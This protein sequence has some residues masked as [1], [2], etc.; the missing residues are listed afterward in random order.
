[1]PKLCKHGAKICGV[2]A[3]F[4]ACVNGLKSDFS[5]VP[6][7]VKLLELKSVFCLT[8]RLFKFTKYKITITKTW[9]KILRIGFNI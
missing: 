2:L 4:F 3:I 9:N 5:T 7:N 6:E 8:S 1:M